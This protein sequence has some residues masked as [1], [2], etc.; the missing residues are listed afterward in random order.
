MSTTIDFRVD[1][2]GRL[3]GELA[4]V[5]DFDYIVP[6]GRRLTE[7]EAVTCY[8]QPGTTG[9]GLQSCGEFLLRRDGRPLYDPTSTRLRC[10]DWYRFR[11]P[12]QTWQRPYY[13]E[14]AKVEG[15]IDLATEMALITG[16][17]G[18]MDALWLDHGLA[19]G[20]MAFAYVESGLARV[21]NVAAR[22]ALSDTLTT[23]LAFNTADKL[24][25]AQAIAIYAF[26]LADSVAGLDAETGRRA[27]LEDERWQPVRRIVEEAIALDDW[28]EMIVAVNTVIEPLLCEPLRRIHFGSVA[29]R[30]GDRVSPVIAASASRDWLRNRRWTGA[31]LHFVSESDRNRSLIA[32]WFARWSGRVGQV[33]RDLVQGM[34]TDLEVPE[35]ADAAMAVAEAE[36][37]A[38]AAGLLGEGGTQ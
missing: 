32:E 24:R 34:S 20:Y 2:T 35:A 31:F 12:N 9:G 19:R 29:G 30:H 4:G 28:G 36:Q 5:R 37:A 25:H 6:A 16:A 27:W 1:T 26:D 3:P 38:V 22:E 14:Q 8:T 17:A 10:D 33:A 21:L 15:A 13:A 11:D 7:Y 23:T 18:E